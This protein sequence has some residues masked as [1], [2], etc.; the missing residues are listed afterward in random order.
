MHKSQCGHDAFGSGPLWAGADVDMFKRQYLQ[1]SL[2]MP[3]E[4]VAGMGS[5]PGPG[6]SSTHRSK[7]PVLPFGVAWE[8]RSSMESLIL[9][10]D[11]RWRRA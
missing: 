6:S 1:T 7:L 2:G 10:Q 4:S 3:A 9:A 11:E 5:V 8:A